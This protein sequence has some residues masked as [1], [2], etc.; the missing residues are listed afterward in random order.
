MLI[1]AGT[2][3]ALLAAV[4]VPNWLTVVVFIVLFIGASA[5]SALVTYRLRR[6]TS[7]VK[8]PELNDT[9]APKEVHDE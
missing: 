8:S 3:A 7:K 6:N 9:D 5:V 4:N 2:C 1:S